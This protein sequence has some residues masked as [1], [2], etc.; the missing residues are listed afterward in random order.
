MPTPSPK[1]DRPRP[2]QMS[3]AEPAWRV[4]LQSALIVL[5]GWFVFSPALHGT[6]L[7]DDQ[8]LITQNPEIRDPAG[9]AKIWF[10]PAGGDYF[11]LTST[12]EWVQW[13]LWHDHP[14]GY[15]F[16]SL[17]F[18]LLSALLLWRLL[19][20]LG[21]RQ[22]WLG[23]LIFAVHPVV[24]ESVAWVAEQKNTVSLPLLL[25]AMS[26][27]L[28]YDRRQH[29]LDYG[30]ALL[31]F[32]AALLGK[33]SVV[34]LPGVIL[35]YHWWKEGRIARKHL[36]ASLPFFAASLALG[37]VTVWFQLHRAAAGWAMP[38]GGW[39]SRAA[40]VGLALIFYFSKCVFPVGLVPVYPRWVVEPPSPIQ[41]LPWFA[42]GAGL[43]WCWTWRATWGRHAL[44]GLGF[45]LINLAPVLGFIPMAYQHYTWVAD[46]FV[47]LPLVGLVGLAAAGAGT[48]LD[49][50]AP[51]MRPY[52]VGGGLALLLLLASASHRYAANFRSEEALWTYTLE[53]NPQAWVAHN[54]LGN[55]LLQNGQLLE[56]TVHFE[57]AI[58][59]NPA[60]AEPHN[61][62]GNALHRLGRTPEAIAQFEQA[63]RL[64]ADFAEAHANLGNCLVEVGRA[65]E[66][67]GHYR[68]ALRI[69]PGMV[70]VFNNLGNTLF[71]AGQTQEG[72]RLLQQAVTIKPDYAEGQ[73]N[74]GKMLA[75]VGSLPEAIEHFEIALRLQPDQAATH[76]D[77]GLALSLA[78]R[79]TEAIEHFNQA[80]RLR[81]DLADAHANLGS[82]LYQTGRR[83]E[84]VSHF[85]A[86][87]RL[88]PKQATARRYQQLIP[89]Q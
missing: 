31:L 73:D 76:N 72:M 64:N 38:V 41:F 13:R 25:A 27:Y 28:D 65:P 55:A 32:V 69:S 80:L 52:A 36:L 17:G 35:L 10:Q 40:S 5:A 48:L 58:S 88:D 56:A 19:R 60:Y 37:L 89:R 63:L 81:P 61:N 57:Q 18:H 9:L 29:R 78:G 51:T 33:T 39:A 83:Q 74:L 15:H 26:F 71:L 66:A 42:I 23:G 3:P 30:L 67:I 82:A 75:R 46:H 34:M 45:F 84:A 11:P 20:Q 2:N 86:A 4:W 12:I 54:N 21:I 14:T 44:F 22:A 24:V 50:L 87:L 8:A 85:E 7:W 53:R 79:W 77:L 70:E 1:N 6:W 59:F 49:R 47:Y 43:F 16:S 68:Q 62:L